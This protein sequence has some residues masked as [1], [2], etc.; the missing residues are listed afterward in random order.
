[1]FKGFQFP[2]YIILL[3]VRYYISY[4]LSYREIEEILAERGIRVDHATINRWGI[5]FAPIIEANA[6]RLKRKVG[7]SWRMD[8]T[9]IKIKGEW[10]FY[11]R[12]VDKKG[13]IVDFYLS[14]TRDAQAASTFFKKAIDTNG[15]PE[16]VVIDKS[17]A[18]RAGLEYLNMLFL[19]SGYFL[20]LGI[21]II[22]VK[23]L[24]NISLQNH[25]FIK[26]KMIQ[27]L[28]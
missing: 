19:I 13:D 1:M 17:G 24:N 16:K 23:Y 12:A 27:A 25:R 20:F 21:E 2:R 28:G 11:Y 4:K 7:S 8:E 5:R 9:Y 18:N 26:Q 3:A 15:L 22:D 14:K 10:W 6:R